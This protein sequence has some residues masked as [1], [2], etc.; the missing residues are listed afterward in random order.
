M[1]FQQFRHDEG[2]C[3]SY[4]I[5]CTQ[6]QVCAVIDPH[7][8]I[9]R[10]T[11]YASSCQMTITH[12][13]ETHSQ[14][15]H[16]S[17]AKK[18]SE[19]TGASV[20]FHESVKAAFPIKKIRDGERIT[21]GNIEFTV[22]HTP[23]HTPDSIS[24]L[25]SD[26]T[27]S[28]DPWFVFTGDTLFVG[29]TGR[30]D[31]DGNA[32]Q[33]YDSIWGKLLTLNDSVEVYPTHFAGSSCGRALSPKPSSTIG[34]E[35]RY[36]PSLQAASKREFVEFVMAN[37]PVQPPRFHK[38]REFNLGFLTDPPIERT[39]A[40][41]ALQISVEQLKEK[42]EKGEQPVVVDVREPSEYQKANIGAKLIPLGE[43]PKRLNELDKNAEII[44]HCHHGGRSQRAVEF[45]YENG[46][47]NV[48]NLV[49]GID[50]WSVKIDPKV[51]RY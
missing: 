23:G 40:M 19:H 10:Y 42:L 1:V 18:L 8:D 16:L 41:E 33:L 22:L 29:D 4:L 28:K 26:I 30:P 11:A 32:E 17:G 14:A 44:V 36:N 43:I 45:L 35:R 24:L 20:C 3:L 37:L 2:G 39:Y 49:G 15:D 51:P 6:K 50:A 12:I 34:F 48:K 27:R 13:F 7:L 31:L 47:K 9:D 5:G 25:V 21:I 38:V 46:F